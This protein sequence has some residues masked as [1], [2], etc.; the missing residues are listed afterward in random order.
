[1]SL[2]TRCAACGTVFR[3]VQDQL[4]VSAGWV[5]CG[6]CGEVFNA[7]ESLV[8]LELDRAGE[9][10]MP[11]VHG[12]RVMDDLAKVAGTRLPGGEASAAMAPS[13][14]S[15]VTMRPGFRDPIGGDAVAENKPPDAPALAESIV[16]GIGGGADVTDGLPDEAGSLL[17]PST[18]AE[19]EAEEALP[20][21]HPEATGVHMACTAD[22]PASVAPLSAQEVRTSWT[23]SSSSPTFVRNADR[24][25]RWRSPVAR[26]VLSASCLVALGGLLWQMHYSHH[27]WIAARW[28]TL[29]PS[30]E[31]ACAVSGCVVGAPRQIE[32]LVVESSGLVRDGAVDSYRLALVLRN[33]SRWAL[34]VPAIDLVMTDAQ[35]GVVARR[36]IDAQAAG[37]RADFISGES[38]LALATRRH[39]M[40]PPIVGYTIELFYP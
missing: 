7:I 36:V 4:R 25:A 6:R 35:G 39:V 22:A 18:P 37:V 11:S 34:Q 10:S 24:A 31:W 8:D 28:P 19:A 14:A 33:R 29:G 17:H 3:V 15:D 30:I 27:D 38:D 1:M 32:G 5:R 12:A 23:P 2:A 9:G 21:D 20:P 13:V 16:D 26:T 40:G